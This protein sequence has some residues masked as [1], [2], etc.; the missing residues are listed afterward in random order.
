MTARIVERVLSSRRY[1][2]ID[3]ALVER[4]AAEE[5][6]RSKGADDAVKRVKRRLHQAVG[7]FGRSRMRSSLADAWDGDM[8]GPAFRAACLEALAGHASTRERTAHLDRFYAAIWEH[9][10]VPGSVLDLGCGLGP[11]AV[12]WMGLDPAAHYV[13][14]DV[15]RRVLD[16]VD[17]FLALVGQPHVPRALDLVSAVPTDEA[18]V[19]LA[20][21]LVTTLD[22]QDPQAAA[23]LL[24]SVR[25]P[26]AVVSF[27]TRSLGGQVRGMERTYRSRLERLVAE[28]P[29]VT[30][31]KEA[32]VPNE[33]VFVLA[34][35][36]AS[37]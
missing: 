17:A 11:L 35:G 14:V 30:G 33:L 5:L 7:A 10:G 34:L 18:D 4:L 36:P 24:G 6:P 22:R 1:R 2:G 13:A 37:G 15:D 16:R 12:P 3:A 26:H 32:S 20:L 31:V 25:T 27:T 8:A 28:V 29:R 21:K 19:V 23:R 9:T